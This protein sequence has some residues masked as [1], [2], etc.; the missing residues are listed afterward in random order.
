MHW[1]HYTLQDIIPASIITYVND[2]LVL[3]LLNSVT[4]VK[5]ANVRIFNLLRR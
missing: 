4:K 5:E 3:V 2:K 1:S